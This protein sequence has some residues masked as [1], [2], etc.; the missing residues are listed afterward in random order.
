[1]ITGVGHIN[2]DRFGA[3]RSRCAV[4]AYDYTVLAGTQGYFNHH[5]TD[6]ML[7]VAREN[8]LP[9]I[10][11]AEGGGGRPGDLDPPKAGGL[12]THTWTALGVLSGK[13]PT[14]GIVSGPCFAGNA[15]LL[16]CC[17]VIIATEDSNIGMAGPAMIEGG[18][19]GVF[20]P[21]EIGPI[22]VQR[23]NGVVDLAVKDEAEAVVVAKKY[24]S[25]FQGDLDT[26]QAHDQRELRHVVPENRKRAYDVRR[27]V[28]LV[29]DVDSV[30]EL[31]A[32]FGQTVIT[33]L[34]R[35]EGRTVGVMASN[36][37]VLGGAIDSDGADKA[38]R[39]MQLCD[40]FGFPIVSLC[41]TPG[42]MVG[43][44]SEETAA[45]R[46]FSR[47]FLTGANI[48]VPVVAIVLRKAYGL[49]A[50]AMVGGSLHAPLMT[51]AWP[52]GE[53]GGMGLEGYV[54]LGFRKELE[55]IADD[56]E[57][58]ARYEE[59]VAQMYERGGAINVAMHLE[60]DDVIDPID[61][62]RTILSAIPAV[63]KTGWSNAKVS[64]FVDAW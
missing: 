35:I 7:H 58:N 25:Y 42:F 23:G 20:K 29:C 10:L 5:K 57:R 37:A 48:N 30:M 2:G 52:T 51:A 28:E 3:D 8:D 13:V 6:R 4:M 62:R 31:R 41:D 36:T 12:V 11:F 55:A 17:D 63:A 27:A 21:T 18:G 47:M 24:L 33:S 34:G 14:I 16:G 39:F 49:G 19:L 40:A 38:S 22:D 43:P 46:H 44:E 54:R 45:V 61:T 26:W 9:V 15:A 60:V 50:M 64:R 1:M 56:E 53:F 59:L 32:D